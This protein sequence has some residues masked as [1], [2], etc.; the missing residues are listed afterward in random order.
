M[1]QGAQKML[2]NDAGIEIYLATKDGT[3]ALLV[4]AECGSGEVF[5]ML[6][7]YYDKTDKLE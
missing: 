5:E 3:T 6:L 4:A 7:G 1:R 2:P